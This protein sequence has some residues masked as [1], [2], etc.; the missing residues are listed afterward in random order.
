MREIHELIT[1]DDNNNMLTAM[2]G[3]DDVSGQ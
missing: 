1:S 2:G 3:N